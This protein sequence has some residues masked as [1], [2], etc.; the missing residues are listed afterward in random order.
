MTIM[1]NSNITL[2]K[3]SGGFCFM[4]VAQTKAEI[5]SI[6]CTVAHEI[7]YSYNIATS[8]TMAQWDLNSKPKELR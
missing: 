4:T 3:L 7:D 8:C 5:Q 1:H 2:N 6:S